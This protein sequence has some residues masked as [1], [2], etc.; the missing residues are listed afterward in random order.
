MP[1]LRIVK[2]DGATQVVPRL[3]VQRISG[4]GT[5]AILSPRL[6]VQ[7]IT[8]TGPVPTKPRLRVLRVLASGIV[9]LILNPLA[10]RSS[11]EPESRVQMTATVQAGN[12]DSWTWRQLSGPPVTL[13]GSGATIA[14]TAPSSMS[15]AT[16]VLGV[17]ASSASVVS[18]ERTV[19]IQVL[20]QTLWNYISGT[21]R[22][23]PETTW[24]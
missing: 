23:A 18:A 6:R 5:A 12:P 11:V 10:D 7:Q 15:T 22:G 24:L 16:V 20:P 19:S 4:T 17:T 14:F 21:W 8:G 13:V 1:R 2:V 9:S 3:R